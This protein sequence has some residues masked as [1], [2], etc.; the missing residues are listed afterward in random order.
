M[1]HNA[2]KGGLVQGRRNVESGHL[3]KIAQ[4]SKGKIWITDGVYNRRID[5]GDYIED[6]WQKG[7][8]K[9]KKV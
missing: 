9:R 7:L 4:L 2:K 3:K 1:Q 5:K 8:T 6:G